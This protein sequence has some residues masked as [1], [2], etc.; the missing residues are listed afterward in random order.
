MERYWGGSWGGCTVT[1]SAISSAMG[2][3]TLNRVERSGLCRALIFVIK[4]NTLR[5]ATLTP[6]PPLLAP[7]PLTYSLLTNSI[8]YYT[9]PPPYYSSP[10]SLSP[11]VGVVYFLGPGQF[12]ERW[13]G[14]YALTNLD[15]C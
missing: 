2:F 6:T 13:I 12:P 14:L 4:F 1:V 10:A 11:A 7:P 9:L 8:Q 3:F 5:V 15:H